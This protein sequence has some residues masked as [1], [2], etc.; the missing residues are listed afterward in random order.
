M[1]DRTNALALSADVARIVSDSFLSGEPL[2]QVDPFQSP[3]EDTKVCVSD[4]LTLEEE[5]LDKFG[6]YDSECDVWLAPRLHYVLRLTRRQAG[7]KGLWRWLSLSVLSRYVRHRWAKD[8]KVTAYRYLGGGF[9]RRRNAISRLWWGAETMRVGPDYT[10]AESIFRNSGVEQYVLD[11]R[12]GDLSASAI[13][14]SRVALGAVVGRALTF[15][16]TRDLSIR[17]NLLLSAT[18]LESLSAPGVEE[19]GAVDDEWL[20]E[21]ADVDLARH[22]SAKALRGPADHRVSDDEIHAYEQW[23]GEI[24]MKVATK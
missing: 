12:F 5:A 9:F 13:A 17:A 15:D 16:E 18:S 7:N 24:A 21:E 4:L 6:P 2:G 1:A 3:I 19:I 14:F 11:S 8:D 20:K 10:T 23:Y 22:N